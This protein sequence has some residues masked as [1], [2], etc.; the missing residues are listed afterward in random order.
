M[1]KHAKAT[2]LQVIVKAGNVMFRNQIAQVIANHL[3]A[4]GFTVE[5]KFLRNELSTAGAVDGVI[6]IVTRNQL[7]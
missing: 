6:T 3:S 7:E 2:D 5:E 4:S 1:I